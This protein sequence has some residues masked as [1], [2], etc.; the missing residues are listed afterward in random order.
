M[1]TQATITVSISQPA[2]IEAVVSQP[3]NIQPQLNQPP[4]VQTSQTIFPITANQNMIGVK[5]DPGEKGEKGA[6]I[7]QA[8]FT[9]DD[10]I[11]TKDDSNTVVLPNAKIELK[12]DKGDRGEPGAG[13]VIPSGV[14]NNIVIIDANEE[15][16][17]SGKSINDMATKTGTETLT[18]KTLTSPI[19]TT[20]KINDSSADHKYNLSVSELTADRTVTIPLL[21]GNDEVVFKDH[22]QTLTN[23]TLTSPTVNGGSIN[24]VNLNQSNFNSDGSAEWAFDAGG[25]GS[26]SLADNAVATPFGGTNNF[27]GFFMIHSLTNTVWAFVIASANIV[28][29]VEQSYSDYSTT[30]DTASKINIYIESNVVKIQNKTGES[31]NLRIIA[32]RT[33]STN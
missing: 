19:L 1:P 4:P 18:N 15:I 11:F 22:T 23:K 13:G 20:P 26:F 30:K 24:N 16:E 27:G 25:V 9:G 10:I 14:E 29:I 3:A 32:F 28:K 6:S 7:I 8:A 5:G 12:G 21:T 33:R 17:D 31:H 2:P